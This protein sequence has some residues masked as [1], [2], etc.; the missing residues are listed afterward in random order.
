MKEELILECSVLMEQ[1][2]MYVLTCCN[3]TEMTRGDFMALDLFYEAQERNEKLTVTAISSKTS[4]SKAAV[5]QMIK[6]MEKRKWVLRETD[7]NDK[8]L[9]YV[10]LTD[11]GRKAFEKQRDIMTEN[12]KD[13]IADMGEANLIN[14]N[15]C[16]KMIAARIACKKNT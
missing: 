8:R 2:R 15:R 13:C 14:L 9:V 7:A 11:F 1:I 16:L 10:S 12:L 3:F 5:S 6:I 4:V